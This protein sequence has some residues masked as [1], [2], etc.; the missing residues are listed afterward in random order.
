MDNTTRVRLRTVAVIIQRERVPGFVYGC[1]FRTPWRHAA[2]PQLVEN[3]NVPEVF[4][5]KGGAVDDV[6]VSEFEHVEVG[7]LAIT[8]VI[9]GVYGTGRRNQLLG[10]RA[11]P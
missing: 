5:Q 7:R 8:T 9:S 1:Q 2:S 6:G 10:E 4:R 11:A 3:F